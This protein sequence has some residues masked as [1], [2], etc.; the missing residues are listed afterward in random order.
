MPPMIQDEARHSSCFSVSFAATRQRGD[1]LDAL[2]NRI[3]QESTASAWLL[4][5]KRYRRFSSIAALSSRESSNKI[6]TLQLPSENE[7]SSNVKKMK[8]GRNSGC[9][10]HSQ[11][12][13]TATQSKQNSSHITLSFKKP[14]IIQKRKTKTDEAKSDPQKGYGQ[15]S[16]R[17]SVRPSAG[18]AKQA[19]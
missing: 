6:R 11:K 17:P 4:K 2:Q 13:N 3:N 1:Q 7:N 16:V 8:H 12:Q 19:F 15:P 10:L 5:P 9:R 14:E 18:T